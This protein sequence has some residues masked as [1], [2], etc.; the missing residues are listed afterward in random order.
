MS[1]KR[2]VLA[3]EQ[4]PI[5]EMSANQQGEMSVSKKWPLQ[6]R[7][8]RLTGSIEYRIGDKLESAEIRELCKREDWQVDI[9]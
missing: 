7:V 5:A 9:E 8:K 4:V 3:Q 1:R 6:Y 2:I